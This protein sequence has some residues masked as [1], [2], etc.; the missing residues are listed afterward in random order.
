MDFAKYNK[1]DWLF[2]TIPGKKSIFEKFCA[3]SLAYRDAGACPRSPFSEKS[4]VDSTPK[5]HYSS[6]PSVN[7]VPGKPGLE[8][9]RWIL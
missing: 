2:P 9:A 3:L 7:A 4:K 8:E 6:I 1:I 5:D